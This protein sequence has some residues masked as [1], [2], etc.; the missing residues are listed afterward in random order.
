MSTGFCVNYIKLHGGTGFNDSTVYVGN[1]NFTA[2]F[3]KKIVKVHHV[4][5]HPRYN[6]KDPIYTSDFDV[7][8]VLVSLFISSGF[9]IESFICLEEPLISQVNLLEILD[10]KHFE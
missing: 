3:A 10:V 2:R 5:Y 1:V 9:V 8:Y 4:N 7:G 6:P